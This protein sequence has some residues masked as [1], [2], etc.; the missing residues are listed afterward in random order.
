MEKRQSKNPIQLGAQALGSRQ[1]KIISGILNNCKTQLSD[2]QTSLVKL[3]NP[4][5]KVVASPQIT[6]TLMDKDG[7]LTEF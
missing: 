6:P 1:P 4:Q 7:F 3:W 2:Q 5:Q